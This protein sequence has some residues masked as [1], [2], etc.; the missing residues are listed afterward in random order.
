LACS[1]NVNAEGIGFRG[2]FVVVVVDIVAILAPRFVIAGLLPT[3]RRNG[4]DLEMMSEKN[5][6]LGQ[7]YSSLLDM[8]RPFNFSSKLTWC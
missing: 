1:S 2:A 7:D 3:S 4:E 5:I 6:G 8:Y